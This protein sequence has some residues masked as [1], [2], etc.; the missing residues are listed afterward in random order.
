MRLQANHMEQ[1]GETE[2]LEGC[3]EQ[4]VL[5]EYAFDLFT[6]SGWEEYSAQHPGTEEMPQSR[7]WYV[8]F[9]K[10]E[11]E[12]FYT[13][14]LDKEYFTKDDTIRMARSVRFTREAF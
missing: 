11:S 3:E 7:Y 9:G 4:A 2:I 5:M 6:A 10:E 1:L 12:I 13:L 14:F 8:F